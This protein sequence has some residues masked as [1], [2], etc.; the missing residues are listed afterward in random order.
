MWNLFLLNFNLICIFWLS[1]VP[2]YL[3]YILQIIWCN[4]FVLNLTHSLFQEVIKF[5]KIVL[6][7]S[8]SHSFSEEIYIF[9]FKGTFLRNSDSNYNICIIY[10]VKLWIIEKYK[11]SLHLLENASF[12][13]VKRTS[14]SSSVHL[15]RYKWNKNIRRKLRWD[16]NWRHKS[17]VNFCVLY[18]SPSLVA[19]SAFKMIRTFSGQTGAVH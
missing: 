3:G 2:S 1:G 8:H 11:L 13:Y 4:P 7:T 10:L 6:W 15:L 16:P 5:L 19:F 17:Q 14:R 18:W 9:S 12:K